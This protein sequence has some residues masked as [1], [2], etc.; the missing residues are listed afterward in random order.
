MKKLL[1]SMLLLLI[2]IIATRYIP[3]FSFLNFTN[4]SDENFNDLLTAFELLLAVILATIKFLK[5]RRENR[6]LVFDF[7]TDNSF[8]SL[9]TP[10][11]FDTLN[12]KLIYYSNIT[13]LNN[14]SVCCYGINFK[15]S[16]A[17]IYNSICIPLII[18][19]NSNSKINHLRFSYI[20]VYLVSENKTNKICNDNS[21]FSIRV[22]EDGNSYLG[23][24]IFCNRN[25]EKT[26]LNGRFIIM[27]KT[28]AYNDNDKSIK[29]Y[30]II[31]SQC[32]NG[33]SHIYDFCQCRSYIKFL[34]IKL[35][36]VC[37]R[38]KKILKN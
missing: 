22:S 12:D 14:E 9:S 31:Y 38:C 37:F 15:Y 21:C 16:K 23:I 7:K 10:Q 19:I 1:I 28:K 17:N 25:D 29:K 11:I 30:I 35:R 18:K 34:F 32:I 20:T 4:L 24:D 27:A 2:F 36:C 6:K 3:V 8:L 26:L 13:I 5:D 33:I